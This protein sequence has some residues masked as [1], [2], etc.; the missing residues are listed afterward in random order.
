MGGH[1]GRWGPGPS[2]SLWN[3][4]WILQVVRRFWRSRGPGQICIVGVWLWSTWASLVAQM[5]KNLPVNARTTGDLGSIPGGGNG[6]PL[7][8]SGLENPT[9]RGVW[10]A[11]SLWDCKESDMTEWLTFIFSLKWMDW[12]PGIQRDWS[13]RAVHSIGH[14]GLLA[15][16]TAQGYSENENKIAL[17][18]CL[19]S[20]QIYASLKWLLMP[21]FQVFLKV[22][23]SKSHQDRKT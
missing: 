5:V 19:S 3:L 9:D 11:N 1:R 10:L 21:E 17:K 23:N 20:P 15:N 7:Q 4:H 16:P 18:L 6:S 13:K 2:S 8:Y 12:W 22:H 14:T